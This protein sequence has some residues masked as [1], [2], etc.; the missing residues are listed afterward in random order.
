LQKRSLIAA[1]WAFGAYSLLPPSCLGQALPKFGIAV[2]ASTLGAGI[3]AATAVA[4]HTNLRFGFNYFN[5]SH[6]FVKDGINYNGKLKLESGEL[7]VD[8]YA[9]GV[10][11]ISTGLMFYDGNKGTGTGK[12][13][14]GQS[15]TLGGVTYFSDVTNPTNGTGSIQARKV[16]PEILIGFG[17]MLPRNNKH[18]TANFEV[19]VAFQG[20]PS[21]KLNLTGSACTGQGVNCLA[22]ASSSAIQAN[23]QAE[24]DKINKDLSV[25][26]YYPIVRLTLGYKF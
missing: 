12:A 25:F 15:F 22:I 11:H 5:Y 21:A 20:S 18:F 16:A 13:A 8:Q 2:S 6:D 4:Q 23:V 17:N 14:G 24:Q 9:G 7:L 19:G 26:K 1:F 10:F 3:E